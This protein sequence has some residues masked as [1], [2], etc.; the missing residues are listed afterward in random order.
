MGLTRREYALRTVRYNALSTDD[1][2]ILNLEAARQRVGQLVRQHISAD[3]GTRFIVL[4]KRAAACMPKPVRR[5]E[6]CATNGSFLVLPHTSG[7]NRW[8]NS[9]ENT[10]LARA[11]V[12]SHMA[13]AGGLGPLP[14]NPL[15]EP[16]EELLRALQERLP[17]ARLPPGAYLPKEEYDWLVTYWHHDTWMHSSVSRIMASYPA[18]VLGQAGLALVPHAIAELESGVPRQPWGLF[19]LLEQITGCRPHSPEEAGNYRAMTQ[20]W[21]E[22]YAQITTPR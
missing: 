19:S 5:T 9:P 12:A 10:A 18:K 8:Y 21:T 11:A 3:S 1:G 7:V 2:F 4:G 6:Y 14:H 22:W 16:S 15:Q 13:A 17:G 20:R